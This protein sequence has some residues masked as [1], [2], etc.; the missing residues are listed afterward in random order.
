MEKI[1]REIGYES[2]RLDT[3]VVLLSAPLLLTL[4]R[5]RG[6]IE[7][8]SGWFPGLVNHPLSGLLAVIFQ[9]CAFFLLVGLI[10]AL[11]AR[12]RRGVPLSGLGSGA[13]DLR[14]GLP[15]VVFALPFIIIPIAYLSSRMP[16]IRA[17][18]PM[19]RILF[20]RSDLVLWYELA[21]VLIYYTAWEFFFRG[22]LLFSLEK[23]FGG[24]NAVLVQTISSS[25]VHIGKPESEILGSIV[26]GVVFGS[27]ALR[28]RSFWYGWLLH[29]AIGVSVD[30]F[31]LFL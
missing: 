22:F 19:A 27:L 14:F 12:L 26:A 30:L 2:E 20:H 17:E 24:F 13:G 15:L 6:S 11:Y 5:T 18:Y 21:Y 7:S 31:V 16:E 9:W 23:V 8:F 25:L 10:P 28:T 4:Y 29:A 1:L 3:Y